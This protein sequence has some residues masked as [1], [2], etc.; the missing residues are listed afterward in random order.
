MRD[1]GTLPHHVARTMRAASFFTAILI[2][3]LG[4]EIARA[5]TDFT[6]HGG[7]WNGIGRFLAMADEESVSLAVTSS[8]DAHA[9]D[10][11]E[12]V[13]LLEVAPGRDVARLS[14]FVD[15]GGLLVIADESEAVTPLFAR[16][17][18]VRFDDP[19]PEAA[20]LP[21][22]EG[23]YL[24]T[25]ILEHP[26]VDGV[27]YLVTNLPRPFAHPGLSPIAAFDD[28]RHLLAVG[29]LGQ[30]EIVAIGDGSLFIDQSLELRENA[31]FAR[32]LLRHLRDRSRVHLVVGPGRVVGA[33]AGSG[34]RGAIRDLRDA[35]NRVASIPTPPVGLYFTAVALLAF[36][37]VYVA[38]KF[39]GSEAFQGPRTLVLRGTE[40]GVAGRVAFHRE[41]SSNLRSPALVYRRTLYEAL[42]TM[43]DAEVKNPAQAAARLRG[44]DESLATS[45][46]EL[47]ERLERVHAARSGEIGHRVSRRDYLQLVERGEALLREVERRTGAP[48]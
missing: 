33:P 12:A 13:I 47:L 38:A 20:R 21:S 22:R 6:V 9:L 26:L 29:R 15:R 39:F 5:E 17:G 4:A 45:A 41:H 48:R 14:A 42:S 8:L 37:V 16:L 43:L 46:T 11:G 2:I 31:R 32:N 34:D 44:L 1:G 27:G 18:F 10:P 35:L 23:V 24:S 3:A 36:T 19:G 25:P 30:G 28:E 40:G 7:R